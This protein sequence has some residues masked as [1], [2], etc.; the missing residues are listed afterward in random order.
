[1]SYYYDDYCKDSKRN[2]MTVIKAVR[3]MTNVIK[4]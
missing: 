3:A 2:I 4:T 1:M